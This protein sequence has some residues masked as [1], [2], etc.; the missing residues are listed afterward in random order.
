[1][2]ESLG[3]LVFPGYGSSI[4]KSNL[5]TIDP[6]YQPDSDILIHFNITDSFGNEVY[7]HMVPHTYN[8]I[9]HNATSPNEIYKEGSLL[10]DS[11]NK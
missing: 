9:I 3:F 11:V 6:S 10:F 2:N 5:T 4:A 8:Y 1:M 7:E